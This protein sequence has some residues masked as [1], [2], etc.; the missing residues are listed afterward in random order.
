MLY[1]DSYISFT[2]Q[3]FGQSRIVADRRLPSRTG[4]QIA[5]VFADHIGMLARFEQLPAA[6]PCLPFV[7]LG[8]GHCDNLG[9]GGVT[10]LDLED[11]EG[12]MRLAA[13]VGGVSWG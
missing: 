12:P 9:A 13:F 7:A 10:V 1:Q 2:Q 8:Q 5:A 3:R 4:W 11:T 6:D